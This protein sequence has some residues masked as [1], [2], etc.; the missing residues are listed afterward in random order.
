VS[1]REFDALGID[2]FDDNLTGTVKFYYS[3]DEPDPVAPQIDQYDVALQEQKII[4]VKPERYGQAV[5]LSKPATNPASIPLTILSYIVTFADIRQQFVHPFGG[6][7]VVGEIN[8]TPFKVAKLPLGTVTTGGGGTVTGGATT[9]AN[10]NG[11]LNPQQLAR[12]LLIKMGLDENLAVNSLSDMAKIFDLEWRG[13]HAPTEL[14]KVLQATGHTLC[15]DMT[16][17]IKIVQISQGKVPVIPAPRLV[18]QLPFVPFER[19]G[20]SVA[21]TSA[22]NAVL[23]TKWYYDLVSDDTGADG[24]WEFVIQDKDKNWVRLSESGYVKDAFDAIQ[25]LRGNRT[26][27]KDEAGNDVKDA[28]GNL[29]YSTAYLPSGVYNQL[30]RCIRLFPD[31]YSPAP[32]LREVWLDTDKRSAIDVQAKIAVQRNGIWS[33]SKVFVPVT[34]LSIADNGH[35]LCLNDRLLQ[36]DTP[37]DRRDN[38]CHQIDNSDLKVHLTRELYEQVETRGVAKPGQTGVQR[39]VPKY[40]EAACIQELGQISAPDDAGASNLIDAGKTPIYRRPNMRLLKVDGKDINRASLIDQ[41]SVEAEGLL[42]G[43]GDPAYDII[44]KGFYPGDLD[45]V[46]GNITYDQEGLRTTF[47]TR[48]F[49]LPHADHIAE[50]QKAEETGVGEKFPKQGATQGAKAATGESGY[51]QS[52]VTINAFPAEEQPPGMVK[53]KITDISSAGRGKYLGSFV[54]GASSATANTPLME[55]EGMTEDS[56]TNVLILNLAEDVSVINSTKGTPDHTLPVGEYLGKIVGRG[57]NGA[58]VEID[59]TRCG[60][61]NTVN[62]NHS[63]G[64][65]APYGDSC[66]VA[67]RKMLYLGV[68]T[69]SVYDVG[70]GTLYAYYRTLRFECG[71]LTDVGR[72]IQRTIDITELC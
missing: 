28:N 24:A 4:D 20:A 16:G 7:V 29:V 11:L 54:G 42:T 34:V 26:T 70:S 62:L 61:T 19:R 66:E 14:E 30:F 52:A 60:A 21:F 17:K 13:N 69:R 6:R 64:V 58:I 53:V 8:K 32:I 3:Y 55:P 25:W 51:V 47:N 5:D 63:D 41:C 2:I 22:P 48:T 9:D 23:E 31:T 36:V 40:F 27:T 12:I 1:A 18:A 33:N 56:G 57:S 35:V 45:G 39:Y 59:C 49:F 46:V 72:E 50:Y 37:T 43:S 65:V 44:V 71:I 15:V 68:Q 67:N 38:G 10:G